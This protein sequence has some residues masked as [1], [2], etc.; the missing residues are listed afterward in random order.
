MNIDDLTIG[1]ARE[2]SSL[3]GQQKTGAGAYPVEIGKNYL[4]QGVTHYWTGCVARITGSYAVLADAAWIASTGRFAECIATG[5]V[6]ECEPVGNV[7]V[8]MDACNDIIP[9]LHALPRELK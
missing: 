2:I 6:D 3:V 1:E 5:K 9:W 7:Y 8:N 4:F